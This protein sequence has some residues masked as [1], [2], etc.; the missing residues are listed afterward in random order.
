M[1]DETMMRM[2]RAVGQGW[3][4]K[5]LKF[6]ALLSGM[7]SPQDRINELR[8]RFDDWGERL[9][10]AMRKVIERDRQVIQRLDASLRALS[11]LRVLDRGYAIVFD[12][13]GKAVKSVKQVKKDDSLEIRVGDGSVPAQVR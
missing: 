11:P 12:S 13:H 1:V 9:S 10:A 8:L 5:K 7:K 4:Q 2:A 3:Q 6:E